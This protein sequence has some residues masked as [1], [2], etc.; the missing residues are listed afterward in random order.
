MT[1]R[2]EGGPKGRSNAWV[3]VHDEDVRHLLTPPFFV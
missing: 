1:L 2:F 3:I